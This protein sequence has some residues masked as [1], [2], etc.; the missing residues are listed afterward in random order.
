MIRRHVG[1]GDTRCGWVWLWSSWGGCAHACAKY[2]SVV[3]FSWG[4]C[5]FLPSRLRMKGSVEANAEFVLCSRYQLWK[6][7]AQLRV[8]LVPGPALGRTCPSTQRSFPFLPTGRRVPG[9]G[10]LA[11]VWNTH[12]SLPKTWVFQHAVFRDF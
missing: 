5:S 2:F 9:M 3:P 11:V 6:N 12:H 8:S 4:Q 10:W 1:N 7:I